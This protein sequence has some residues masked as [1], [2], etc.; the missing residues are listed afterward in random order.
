MN[1][2]WCDVV[3]ETLMCW[4]IACVPATEN[5]LPNSKNISFLF[6]ISIH[7]CQ[8]VIWRLFS[9]FFCIHLHGNSER[10]INFYF[11]KKAMLW[12][13]CVFVA[14][15]QHIFTFYVRA[16]KMDIPKLTDWRCVTHIPSAYIVAICWKWTF[17]LWRILL[18]YYQM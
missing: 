5:F 11:C 6:S 2:V 9:N 18:W 16:C 12:K 13:T 8:T 7:A 17:S 14:P 10:E 4:C 3:Q 1:V 15:A